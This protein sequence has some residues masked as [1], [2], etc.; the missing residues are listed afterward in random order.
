MAGD[1][2]CVQIWARPWTGRQE[3]H[4]KRRLHKVSD[5]DDLDDHDDVHDGDDDVDDNDDDDVDELTFL[6][7]RADVLW[8]SQENADSPDYAK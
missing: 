8:I 2:D 6:K 5:N 1:G 3:G 4:W 7:R